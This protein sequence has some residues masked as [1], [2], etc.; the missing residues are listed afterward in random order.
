MTN[1]RHH[2]MDQ[3]V[4]DAVAR[5]VADGTENATQQ[6][7]VLAGFDWMVDKR[8]PDPS[9]F[10]RFKGREVSGAGA[11]ATVMYL[12]QFFTGS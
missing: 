5:V 1:H 11:G 4:K 10:T 7:V 8:T 9:I 3:M 12:V 6:D 2:P